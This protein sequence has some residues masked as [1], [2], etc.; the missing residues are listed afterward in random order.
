VPLARRDGDAA[1]GCKQRK[2]ALQRL[3]CGDDHA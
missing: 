2:L 3:L 1:I